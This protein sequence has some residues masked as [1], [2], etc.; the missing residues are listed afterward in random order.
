MAEATATG[1]NAALGDYRPCPP[2]LIQ[3]TFHLSMKELR[4]DKTDEIF[5]PK[6]S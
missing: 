6:G 5:A 1:Y 4:D 3:Q 2:K